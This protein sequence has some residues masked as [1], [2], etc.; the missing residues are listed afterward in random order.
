MS[1]RESPPCVRSDP[2][3]SLR[4][5][6]EKKHGP[7]GRAGRHDPASSVA[8]IALLFALPASLSR[9]RP[10]HPVSA[11]SFRNEFLVEALASPVSLVARFLVLLHVELWISDR[12]Q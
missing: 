3:S 12:T 6:F 7:P 1:V 10:S 4:T 2:R 9:T 5:R 8:Q 11:W